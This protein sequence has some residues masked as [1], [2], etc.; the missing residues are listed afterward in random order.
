MQDTI[1]ILS[2]VKWTTHEVRYDEN[3]LL[4]TEQSSII[5]NNNFS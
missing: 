4:K 1:Q 3:L 5:P 2:N